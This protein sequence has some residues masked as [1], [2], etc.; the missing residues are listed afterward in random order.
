M[1]NKKDGGDADGFTDKDTAGSRFDS[2]NTSV[3]EDDY[4]IFDHN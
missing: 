1:T 2:F 3:E 4:Y